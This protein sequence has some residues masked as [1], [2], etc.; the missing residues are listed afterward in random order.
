MNIYIVV[1]YY[2]TSGYKSTHFATTSKDDAFE[3]F[4][5]Q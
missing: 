5:K 3:F 1:K 2:F 4:N